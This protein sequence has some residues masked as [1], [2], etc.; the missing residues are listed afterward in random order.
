MRSSFTVTAIA[1]TD[2]GLNMGVEV[3]SKQQAVYVIQTLRE[4][5]TVEIQAI[6]GLTIVDVGQSD[7]FEQEIQGNPNPT[8]RVRF[9]VSLKYTEAFRDQ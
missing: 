3:T 9:T 5:E 8:Q 2:Q 7:L 1:V 4:F 6:S